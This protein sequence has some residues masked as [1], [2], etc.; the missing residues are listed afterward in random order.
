[1]AFTLQL[2][3]PMLYL[4]LAMFRVSAGQNITIGY[5][6]PC[7][8]DNLSCPNVDPSILQCFRSDQICDTIRQCAGGFDESDGLVSLQCSK[9]IAVTF[10]PHSCVNLTCVINCIIRTKRIRTPC[11][12]PSLA[13]ALAL[14]P[15]P[16]PSTS[17][18]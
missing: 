11:C 9:F 10:K 8:G 5:L 17:L 12:L 2:K 3:V 14:A 18:T 6:K 4:L 16:S 13:L 15:Q 1:M 7:G